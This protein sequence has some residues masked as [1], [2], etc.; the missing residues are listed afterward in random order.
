MGKDKTELCALFEKYKSDKCHEIYHT[1]SKL[2]YDL[3][4]DKKNSALNILEIGIGNKE[5]MV[6]IVGQDYQEGASLKAWRDFFTKANVFG[7]DI[8]RSVLFNDNRIYCY[9]ADQSNPEVLTKTVLDINQYHGVDGFDVIIDDGSHI[10]DHMVCSILTLNKFLK[11]GGIYIIEDIKNHD[12]NF[13]ANY[14]P[15]NMVKLLVYIGN[16]G[17]AKTQDNFI[18][19]K[20]SE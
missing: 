19:Y 8:D 5:L 17:K 2:Y 1:Y 3:L 18:V 15:D 12:V 4:C 9:F 20:K 16:T 7:L 6:P 14:V 10:K 13:F 11:N